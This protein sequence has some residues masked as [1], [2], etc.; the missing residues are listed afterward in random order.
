ML[1]ILK[2]YLEFCIRNT[3]QICTK[4]NRH[5]GSVS[6]T[7]F[8]IAG[9]ARPTHAAVTLNADVTSNFRSRYARLTRICKHCPSTAI[10]GTCIRDLREDSPA[11]VPNRLKTSSYYFTDY[12]RKFASR[13]NPLFFYICRLPL[14]F[15]FVLFFTD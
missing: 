6:Q 7:N 11:T 12:L 1:R 2:T 14:F 15:F 10:A 8:S 4:T 3:G 9:K 13:A 5:A